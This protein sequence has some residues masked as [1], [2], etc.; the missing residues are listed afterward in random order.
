[1]APALALAVVAALRLFPGGGRT[2]SAET[3]DE[4]DDGDGGGGD[5]VGDFC[6]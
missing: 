5:S 6:C 4:E 3:E 1:L 2:V